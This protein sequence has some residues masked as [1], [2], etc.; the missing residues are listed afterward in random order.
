M[1]RLDVS[2]ISTDFEI[3]DFQNEAWQKSQKIKLNYYWSGVSSETERRAVSWLLWSENALYI[4]FEGLQEEPLVINNK[5]NITEKATK[6]WER[7]VFEIF[8]APDSE[9]TNRYFEFEVAPTGEWLDIK[10]EILPGGERRADFE[11]SSGMEAGACING[12][13]VL[14]AMKINWQAFGKKPRTG[15][16]WRGN[17]FRCIGAGENRGYLA[18]LPTKTKI[19]NFHVPEAFGYFE[20][21]KNRR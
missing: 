5:P 12:N 11:Y 7:D 17:L 16:I 4:K 3:N 10:L 8:I 19:P 2:Y 15:E 6:L 21:I 9:K 1:N 13:K 20:F 18:W 14:A